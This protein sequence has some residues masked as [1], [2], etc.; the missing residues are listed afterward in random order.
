MAMTLLSDDGIELKGQLI[1]NLYS[2]FANNICYIVRQN[3]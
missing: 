2:D 3:L 1:L